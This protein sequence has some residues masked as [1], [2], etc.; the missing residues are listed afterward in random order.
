MPGSSHFLPNPAAA[1][2]AEAAEPLCR[3]HGTDCPR[4]KRMSSALRDAILAY[5][6]ARVNHGTFYPTDIEALLVMRSDRETVPQC[7]LSRPA[8]CINAQGAKQVMLGG[9]VLDYPAL[10][11]LVVSL[12]LPILGRVT[13]A[14]SSEPFL[15]MAIE[16]DVNLLR[17]VME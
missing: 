13:C 14:S 10:Q 15:G 17:Q 8:L 9:Q 5:T 7:A 16:L 12:D 1:L 3:M 4:K 6:E 2:Y 11:Y